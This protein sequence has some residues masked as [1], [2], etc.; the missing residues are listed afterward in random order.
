L[1]YRHTALVHATFSINV[2]F[3]TFTKA[4]AARS[5]AD[6]CAN[7]VRKA[8]QREPK[9]RERTAE[10]FDGGRSWRDVSTRP[11]SDGLDRKKINRG[12]QKRTSCATL[13]CPKWG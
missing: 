13:L 4:A 10:G 8:V 3:P 9:R 1:I 6:R 11:G 5:T 12:V 7:M 2:V